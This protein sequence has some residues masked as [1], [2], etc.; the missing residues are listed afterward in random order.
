MSVCPDAGPLGRTIRH[1]GPI[2]S[3]T[4]HDYIIPVWMHDALQDEPAA[5]LSGIEAAIR[6]A[7]LREAVPCRMSPDEDPFAVLLMRDMASPLG[8]RAVLDAL[9]QRIQHY[10]RQAR[11]WTPEDEL[12]FGSG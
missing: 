6:D 2:V 12:R 10:R 9:D 1:P 5:A 4:W 8:E 7:I 11:D 3:F